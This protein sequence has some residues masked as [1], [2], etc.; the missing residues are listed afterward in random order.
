M[1][2]PLENISSRNLYCFLIISIRSPCIM[3]LSYSATEQ[4]GTVFLLA[5][6]MQNLPSGVHLLHN[7]LNLVISRCCFAQDGEEMYHNLPCTCKAVVLLI[8][9]FVN[10]RFLCRRRRVCVKSL[11]NDDGDGN[12]NVS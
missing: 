2:T 7:T 6:R 8:K 4:V 11:S 9:P 12:E 3:W 10:S 5:Q 1:K